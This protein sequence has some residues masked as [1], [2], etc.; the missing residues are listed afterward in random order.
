MAES[1]QDGGIDSG[2]ALDPR[3]WPAQR[4]VDETNQPS[5]GENL[6]EK[7]KQGMADTEVKF[8]GSQKTLLLQSLSGTASISLFSGL[9]TNPQYSRG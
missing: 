1:F 4:K 6:G 3:G 8:R 5:Y 9:L 7:A 2:G